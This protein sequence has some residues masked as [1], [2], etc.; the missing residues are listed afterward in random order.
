[1]PRQARQWCRPR[2]QQRLDLG[3][4][5][6]HGDAAGLLDELQA[7]LTFG[8]IEPSANSRRRELRRRRPADRALLGRAPV[9]VDGVDVGRRSASASASRSRREQRAREVLVDHGLDADEP[10]AGRRR[11]VGVHDRDAAAARADHDAVPARA[12]PGSRSMPEDPLRQRRRND[13]AEAVA[14]GLERPALLAGEAR[15]PPPRRRPGR[16]ASSGSRTPGRPGRPRS[17][18]S[19]VA[20]CFSNGS[21]LPSSCWIR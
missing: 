20:R 5:A 4:R 16:S 10:P 18:V 12:A 17:C 3:D 14:V 13:A 8:P 21:T 9:R 6:D 7:A 19:S 2:R 15:R 1:M 11:L